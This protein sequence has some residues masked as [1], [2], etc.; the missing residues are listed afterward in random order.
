MAKING[1][2][3]I[4]A[5]LGKEFAKPLEDKGLEN[6]SFSDFN[7]VAKQLQ[8]LNARDPRN[9][10]IQTGTMYTLQCGGCFCFCG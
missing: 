4:V 2:T 5:A 9:F 6:L 3:K 8:K 1:R 7:T 10:L